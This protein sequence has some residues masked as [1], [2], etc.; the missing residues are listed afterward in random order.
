MIWHHYLQAHSALPSA[1]AVSSPRKTLQ[2]P[3]LDERAA[4]VAL[5]QRISLAL[6]APPV[7]PCF[8]S[9]VRLYDYTLN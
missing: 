1:R 9:F 2:C 6:L 3:S 8:L 7:N 4:P 5:L